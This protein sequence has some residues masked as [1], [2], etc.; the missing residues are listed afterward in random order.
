[1][2]AEALLIEGPSS[3]VD[4]SAVRVLEQIEAD[5]REFSA[6]RAGKPGSRARDDGGRFTGADDGQR[7]GLDAGQ[8]TD[9]A[10]AGGVP[11]TPP[12][13][14]QPTDS[15]STSGDGK[16]AEPAAADGKAEPV[17][18]ES[19]LTPFERAKRREA[20][21]W[22]TI[23]EAKLTNETRAAELTARENALKAR[24]TRLASV[25][26]AA[27]AAAQPANGQGRQFSAKAYL[28]GAAEFEAR[29][30]RF[31]RAGQFDKADEQMALARAAREEAAKA[32]DVPAPVNGQGVHAGQ[33]SSAAIVAGV[34][35]EHDAQLTRN[36]TQLKADMPELLDGNHP[37][38]GEVIAQLRSNPELM[39]DP[40]GP[41]RAAIAA[42]RKVLGKLEADAAGNKAKVGELTAANEALKKQV[43]ELQALTSLPAG[44]QPTS[45]AAPSAEDFASLPADK[46][47]ALLKDELAAL[48]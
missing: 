44:H 48:R 1:M 12:Q 3:E 7:A 25:P 40:A 2:P 42:G 9:T 8:P 22:K 45:R 28:D 30:A 20:K 19:K 5:E 21:T 32:G 43:T 38:N 17:E 46:R 11:Q 41:Y 23:N 4:Q 33:T 36:W 31:E 16:P 13:Q 15:K 14:I 29:A 39:R 37:L 47:E 27:T 10:A 24:E 18:D 35:A 26:A 34:G 6:R